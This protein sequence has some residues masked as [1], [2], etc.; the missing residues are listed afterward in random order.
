SARFRADFLRSGIERF[1]P[2]RHDRDIAAAGCE[3]RSDREANALAAAGNE[4]RFAVVPDFHIAPGPQ[5]A[6]VAP[7]TIH[8]RPPRSMRA[9][10]CHTVSTRSFKER[11]RNASYTCNCS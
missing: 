1:A 4:C 6:L 11:L 9:F 8:A 7:R 2:A 5:V 3:L 10:A